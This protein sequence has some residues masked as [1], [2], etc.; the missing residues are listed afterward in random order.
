MNSTTCTLIILGCWFN[1]ILF[2]NFTGLLMFFKNLRYYP[3]WSFNVYNYAHY[4]S[5]LLVFNPTTKVWICCKSFI[6]GCLHGGKYHLVK[7]TIR[8]NGTQKTL[9]TYSYGIIY[10]LEKQQQHDALGLRLFSSCHI[11][12]LVHCDYNIPFEPNNNKKG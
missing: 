8:S 11:C 10:K 2:C 9:V 12:E 5:I 7:N 4:Q 6:S 3:L 1:Y